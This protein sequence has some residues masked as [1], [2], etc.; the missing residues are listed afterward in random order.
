MNGGE[1]P[2]NNVND[3]RALPS[4][5][6][7]LSSEILNLINGEGA[8]DSFAARHRPPAKIKSM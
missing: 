7:L 2:G 8:E 1:A 3:F 4:E 6:S 5:D